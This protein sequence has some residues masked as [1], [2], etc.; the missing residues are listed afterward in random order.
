MKPIT[1]YW[2]YQGIGGFISDH[3]QRIYE[4]FLN[5][6]AMNYD[7]LYEADDFVYFGDKNQIARRLKEMETMKLI[8]R[9]DWFE[10]TNSGRLATMW[11][12]T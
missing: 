1:S 3:H 11:Y 6:G 2:A 12:L 5:F 4:L 10:P 9:L 8:K 7:Q